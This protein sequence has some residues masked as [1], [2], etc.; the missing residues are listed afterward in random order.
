MHGDFPGSPVI[1][2]PYSQCRGHGSIPGQELRSRMPQGTVKNFLIKNKRIKMKCTGH[3][4]LG[5]SPNAKTGKV[6][7]KRLL[8]VC[9]SLGQ[10]PGTYS[11][12]SY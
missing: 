4:P 8:H 6:P 7:F 2:T 1:K 11:V 10:L 12:F 5:P 9:K 3:T